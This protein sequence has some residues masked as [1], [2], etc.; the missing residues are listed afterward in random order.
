MSVL[1]D[2]KPSFEQLTT[3]AFIIRRQTLVDSDK[4]AVAIN[5][6]KH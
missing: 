6:L 3:A 1:W 4:I 2:P 5:R